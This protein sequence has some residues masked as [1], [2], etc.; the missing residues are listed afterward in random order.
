MQFLREILVQFCALSLPN[1]GIVSISETMP[2]FGQNSTEFCWTQ[3]ARYK[4][5]K[6][7]QVSIFSAKTSLLNR[8]KT[9]I[10][11]RNW[12]QLCRLKLDQR[13]SFRSNEAENNGAA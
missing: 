1:T 3:L 13:E 6:F 4:A 9:S 11:D 2:E 8:L 5:T 7:G 12:A 10:E